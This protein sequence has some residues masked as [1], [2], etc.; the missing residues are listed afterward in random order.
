MDFYFQ[1][2]KV[3]TMARNKFSENATQENIETDVLEAVENDSED[4]SEKPRSEA[5]EKISAAQKGIP[6]QRIVVI[7]QMGEDEPV[8]HASLCAAIVAHGLSKDTDWFTAR[9]ALKSSDKWETKGKI[10]PDPIEGD[11][12]PAEPISEYDVTFKLVSASWK[13]DAKANARTDDT[14]ESPEPTELAESTEAA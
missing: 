7:T 4:M 9:T 14:T 1:H 10:W 5:G 12:Q 6:K 2:N 11:A 13:T 3:N 8:E